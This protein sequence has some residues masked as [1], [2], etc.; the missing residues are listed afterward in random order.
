[1]ERVKQFVLQ[2]F[3][4]VIIGVILLATF[5]ATHLVAEKLIVLHFFYLP[6]LVAGYYLGRRTGVLVSVFSILVVLCYALISPSA[7]LVAWK[8]G[9]LPYSFLRG[10]DFSSWQVW[11]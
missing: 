8:S 10:V 4:A 3:E 2:H 7:S 1:M 11:L 5:G 6:V 9:K